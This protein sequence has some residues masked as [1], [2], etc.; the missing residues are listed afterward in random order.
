M[1]IQLISLALFLLTHSNRQMVN[2]KDRLINLMLAFLMLQ[3]LF[4]FRLD[5]DRVQGLVW[6]RKHSE[7][8]LHISPSS[9]FSQKVWLLSA[10]L[11]SSIL[12]PL[13]RCLFLKPSWGYWANSIGF[14][15]STAFGEL[16][17]SMM[18]LHNLIFPPWRSG[19]DV[20]CYH[21]L[22]WTCS[23]ISSKQF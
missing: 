15:I 11:S 19:C 7:Q 16:F 14:P 8:S 17:S 10:L 23:E 2:V 12:T 6:D 5:P 18:P 4:S 3:R 20:E 13:W 1:G 21:G 9:P 22:K